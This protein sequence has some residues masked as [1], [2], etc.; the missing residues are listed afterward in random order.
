MQKTH[1]VHSRDLPAWPNAACVR[2]L[3]KLY[4]VTLLHFLP[5]TEAIPPCASRLRE[6][7]KSLQKRLVFQVG[8]EPTS[9]VP[10][11]IFR[12]AIGTRLPP[13]V[14]WWTHR[15]LPPGLKLAKLV[16]Y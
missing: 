12:Y 13:R 11:R 7:F 1:S 5:R 2:G 3:S 9:S 4:R 8:F 14:V 10:R 15:V 6:G 16:C